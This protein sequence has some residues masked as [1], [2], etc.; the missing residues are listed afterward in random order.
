MA[1]TDCKH[2]RRAC[3]REGRKNCKKYFP[4]PPQAAT[5]FDAKGYPLYR[6][7]PNDGDIIPFN[8]RLLL[9]FNC[10]MNVE[11][12]ATVNIVSYENTCTSQNLLT[13]RL[14]TTISRVRPPLLL[15]HVFSC[16]TIM[17]P[18]P[19]GRSKK[20][21]QPQVAE[22]RKP[23]MTTYLNTSDFPKPRRHFPHHFQPLCALSPSFTIHDH[24]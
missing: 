4:K 16:T 22:L 21:Q 14:P 10:H 13:Q 7:S 2:T 15:F 9:L 24:Q 12:S 23:N 20:V 18:A 6:R 17:P 1:H 8:K 11:D 3:Y 19:R 5:T